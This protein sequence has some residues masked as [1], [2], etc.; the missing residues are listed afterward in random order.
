M[1]N[2]RE[3]ILELK[4]V[5]KEKVVCINYWLQDSAAMPYA[6]DRPATNLSL[7]EMTEVAISSLV[8]Q[9][10]DERKQHRKDR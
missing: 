1:L 3:S 10:K 5:P 4:K 6:I 2:E 9:P 7:A 8:H